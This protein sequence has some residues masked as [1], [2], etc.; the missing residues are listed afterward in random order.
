V[1]NESVLVNRIKRAIIDRYPLAW[2]FKV[3]GSPQ[4]E[5]GVPDLLVAVDGRLVG[6][7]VKCR[8]A[9]ESEQA[10]RNRATRLQLTQ[11]VQ[12]RDAGC[13]AEVVL[14]HT[15]ALSVIERA[16]KNSSE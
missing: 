12:L 1:S 10:A 16:L 14:S 11:I 3:V 9:G 15:E 7:E 4:Q 2:V 6:L 8:R 5:S 13:T